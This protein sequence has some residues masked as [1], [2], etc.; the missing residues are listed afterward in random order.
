M[1]KPVVVMVVVAFLAMAAETVRAQSTP[2]TCGLDAGTDSL[3]VNVNGRTT[4][5]DASP[6]GILVNGVFCG[7]PDAVESVRVT[8]GGLVDRVTL[9]GAFVPG[10]EFESDWDELEVFVDLAG[11]NDVLTVNA[12]E[13]SDLWRIFTGTGGSGGQVRVN[14]DADD[15]IVVV[16]VETLKLMGNGGD[17]ELRADGL[18]SS[19]KVYLY[20]GAG[21]DFLVGSSSADWLYGEDGNDFMGGDGGNDQLYDGPGGDF[22]LGG[23]GNDRF[24]QGAVPDPNDYFQGHAGSDTLDYSARTTPLNVNIVDAI[25]DDGAFEE[26]DAVVGDVEKVIGGSGN[27]VLIGSGS[28]NTL[29]GGPGDDSL[30]GLGGVDTLNG[31]DGADNL[32]GDAGADKLFGDAGDDNLDGGAGNDTMRGGDG[33]DVLDGGGGADAYFAE[34][35]DDFL[36]NDDGVAETVDCGDGTDDPEVDLGA[37][38]TFVAC[39]LI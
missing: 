4:T 12:S 33:S 25:A 39:E 35:G 37:T 10:V 27:D 38:D 23:E 31:G 24:V 30:Y 3:L 17:D 13:G 6:D 15:D 2:T 9:S 34:G 5:V 29:T 18:V 22:V 1:N 11:G 20:G 36:Y 19:S 7:E 16:S 32:I 8:G 28:G 14:G 21:D 26:F